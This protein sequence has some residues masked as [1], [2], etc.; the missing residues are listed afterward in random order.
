[1]LERKAMRS[2]DEVNYKQSEDRSEAVP[3]LC[4]RTS[5]GGSL[6]PAGSLSSRSP[7]SKQR[8]HPQ[9]DIHTRAPHFCILS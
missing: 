4:C 3:I 1:M 5:S 7:L 6:V 8:V 9:Q 2:S